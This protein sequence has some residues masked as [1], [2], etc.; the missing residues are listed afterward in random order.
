MRQQHK[1]I[2]WL[3]ACCLVVGSSAVSFP[4][5]VLASG[6]VLPSGTTSEEQWGVNAVGAVDFSEYYTRKHGVNAEPLTIAV[7][8]T[9]IHAENRLFDGKLICAKNFTSD[10]G[11]VETDVSDIALGHGTFVSTIILDT[12]GSCNVKLMPIKVIGDDYSPSVQDIANAVDYAVANGAKVINMSMGSV[13]N[14]PSLATDSP[15][16]KSIQAALERDVFVVAAAGNDRLDMDAGDTTVIP[17]EVPGVFTVSAIDK[18]DA[19]WTEITEENQ[20]SNYGT[21][22]DIAAPGVRVGGFRGGDADV[23]LSY[24]SGTSFAAP[25]VTGAAA[26]L[27]IADPTLTV[28][29]LKQKLTDG[30]KNLN[31]TAEDE[32]YFGAGKIDINGLIYPQ[33]LETTLTVS[34]QAVNQGENVTFTL[35]ANDIIREAK[36]QIDGTSYAMTD[37]GSHQTFTYTKTMRKSGTNSVEVTATGYAN[38]IQTKSASVEVTPTGNAAQ[39]DTSWYNTTDTTFTLYTAG[40]LFGLAQIVNGTAPGIARDSFFG[41]TILLGTDI[42]L[43][44]T[45]WIPLGTGRWDSALGSGIFFEGTFNGLY[46]SIRNLLITGEHDGEHDY[47]GLFG[48]IYHATIC[49]LG[50]ESGSIE[51][52]KAVGVIAGRSSSSSIIQ[53][54]NKVDVSAKSQVGGIVGSNNSTVIDGCYN[55]GNVTGTG[56]KIGGIVGYGTSQRISNSYNTGKITATDTAGGIIGEGRD[57]IDNE[58]IS[59]YNCYNTGDII[60]SGGFAGGISGELVDSGIHTCYNKGEVIGAGDTG[61]IVGWMARYH[62]SNVSMSYAFNIGNVSGTVEGTGGL[63]GSL[64]EGAKIDSISWYLKTDAINTDIPAVGVGEQV[65][66]ENSYTSYLLSD[67]SRGRDNITKRGIYYKWENVSGSPKLV[68]PERTLTWITPGLYDSTWPEGKGDGTAEA[69]YLIDNERE[70]AAFAVLVNSG[71]TFSIE[72]IKLNADLDLSPYQWTPI[73]C[74]IDNGFYGKFDGNNKTIRGIVVRANILGGVFGQMRTSAQVKNLTV[75]GIDIIISG[76]NAGGIAANVDNATIEN[77]HVKGGKIQSDAG[78]GYAYVGGIA[79]DLS[80]AKIINCSNTADV[81]AQAAVAGGILGNGLGLGFTPTYIKNCYNAG[82]VSAKDSVGGIVGEQ[83]SEMT[84]Q[85]VYNSG[86]VNATGTQKGAVVGLCNGEIADAYFLQTDDVNTGLEATG[87]TSDQKN[88]CTAFDTTGTLKTAV[89]ASTTLIDALNSKAVTGYRA[90]VGAGSPFP[91]F[92]EYLPNGY[93]LTFQSNG[94]TQIDPQNVWEGKAAVTPADPEKQGYVFGGWYTDRAL[95]ASWDAEAPVVRNLTL[96]AKWT[97]GTSAYTVEH[98]RQDVTG[99]GYTKVDADTQNLTAT[100]DTTATAVAKEYT[101]FTENTAHEARVPSGTVAANGSLVLKLYYDRDTYEVSFDLGEVAGDAP[102]AQTIRYG[103]TAQVPE[104]PTREGYIFDGWYTNDGMTEKWDSDAEVTEALCLYAKW[105]AAEASYTV[106]HYQQDAVGDG[107]TKVNSD[108]E[109]IASSVGA[110]VTAVAKEY[111]GFVENTTHADRIASGTI[112][113][114]GTLLLKLYYDRKTYGVSFD[115]NGAEGTSPEVQSVRYG[116]NAALPNEPKREGYNFAGWY[117][118]EA[119]ETEWKFETDTV[120]K[121]LT[122]Y[123]K[124]EPIFINGFQLEI[125]AQKQ[126]ETTVNIQ[127]QNRGEAIGATVFIAEYDENHCLQKVTMRVDTIP[128]EGYPI[129]YTLEKTTN[130]IGIF[131]WDAQA[132]NL[133]PLCGNQSI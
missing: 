108:T 55:T 130:Q 56:S 41:K 6:A 39:P 103:G 78:T 15:L 124:W 86:L 33:T 63:V 20:G 82:K 66:S 24:D 125:H 43:G 50:I 89:G 126:D 68:M 70:F 122:L 45:E 100:T 59:I 91:S 7:I 114:G 67:L 47:I 18:Y 52:T 110:E 83:S 26:L 87:N 111:T 112:P 96:Y 121:E 19:L 12:V 53:C 23:G 49:N 118:E 37:D 69:P 46:H 2:S 106:E 48:D 97:A 54:Y 34:K 72:H 25:H 31:V 29:Q 94:G 61:G 123:A 95:T 27:R 32:R 75:N 10:N 3:L 51:S 9:G 99:D 8:D 64:D 107:Y 133:V 44:N 73:G 65:G 77:C 104:A 40:E 116:A 120:K 88:H 21:A 17:A 131:V 11:G 58:K 113:A 16:Q 22:V 119:C 4:K 85:N 30:A 62:Q 132:E 57:G 5:E 92:G 84:V 14:V 109:N 102:P 90:W 76:S 1:F 81:I 36:I 38:S 115:L 129:A 35:S 93:T 127:V 71:R 74:D 28:P 42:D 98:Y 101:G 105:T 128:T 79:G 80:S 13:T 60:A 117:Q